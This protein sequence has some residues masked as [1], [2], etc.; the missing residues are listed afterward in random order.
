M[1]ETIGL[2]KVYGT[3]TALDS[4]DLTIQDGEFFALLGVNGAGKTTTIKLLSC[5]VRPSDGDALVNGHSIVSEPLSV[6][7]QIS[8]SPQESA[9]APNLTVLENLALIAGAYGAG[10]KEAKKRAETQLE[11]Y[12]LAEVAKK[13]AKTLSGGWQRRLSLA[14]SLICDPKVLFLDEPT[15]GLDVIARRQLW[16]TIETLKGKVTVILTTHY[17]EEAEALADRIGILVGGKLVALG[18]LSEIL[19]E[20][21]TASLEEAFLRLCSKGGATA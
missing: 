8:V 21:E 5:L 14:M 10:P 19:A 13:R 20:T 18:T 17:L 4:L 1:I 9:V 2:K 6:K 11:Q 3:V 16:Q 7:Q 12:G 15:L